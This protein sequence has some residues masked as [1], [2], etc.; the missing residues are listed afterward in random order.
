MLS[1]GGF[2]QMFTFM[3]PMVLDKLE[4]LDTYVYKIG[5]QSLNFSYATAVGM[6]K[7]LISIL[8]L[9]IANWISKKVNGNSIL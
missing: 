3:N 8:L 5:L 4:N 6:F 2:E 1:G 9:M 7:S